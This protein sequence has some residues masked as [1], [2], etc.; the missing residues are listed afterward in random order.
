MQQMN[1]GAR[2][3]TQPVADAQML[4]SAGLEDKSSRISFIRTVTVGL[5]VTPSL[6]T[7]GG[8]AF[9]AL[10]GLQPKA[11][12]R[13]WGITP[14]PENVCRQATSRATNVIVGL[15]G[16]C[17]SHLGCAVVDLRCSRR[18]IGASHRWVVLG[19]DSRE[20]IAGGAW[21]SRCAG[22][23]TAQTCKCTGCGA[24]QLWPGC[25]R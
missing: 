20:T 11:A 15:C 3:Q 24:R 1:Q 12:Y 16:P 4:R 5:G 13:R 9:Q 14:R 10:A 25:S 18:C 19:A 7:L 22:P 6:L 21:Q 17:Q 23:W 2:R 8:R